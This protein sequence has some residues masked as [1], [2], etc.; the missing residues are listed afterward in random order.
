M[1]RALLCRGCACWRRESTSRYGES[2]MSA[3][4]SGA[5]PE[6]SPAGQLLSALT[7]C[8]PKSSSP[9]IAAARCAPA[10]SPASTSR[11]CEWC[12]ANFSH[13]SRSWLSCTARLASGARV[14]VSE[15]QRAC[16]PRAASRGSNRAAKRGSVGVWVEKPPPW[17]KTTNS[18]LL[19]VQKSNPR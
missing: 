8:S 2:R 11:A 3:S 14:Y 6:L 9:T 4:G 10:E 13:A 12:L 17:T 15:M 19:P 5:H 16:T 7:R 18:S 1:K